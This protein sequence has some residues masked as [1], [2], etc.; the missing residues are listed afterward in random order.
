MSQ[1]KGQKL[2]IHFTGDSSIIDAS[3]I[4][5]ELTFSAFIK[6]LDPPTPVDD[7]VRQYSNGYRRKATT[8]IGSRAQGQIVF[9]KIAGDRLP[10]LDEWIES[11]RGEREF[12]IDATHISGIHRSITAFAD[13]N[14]FPRD[15]VSGRNEYSLSIKYE[16]LN[17][18]GHIKVN[19]VSLQ[20]GVPVAFAFTN[21]STAP[22]RFSHIY[23]PESSVDRSL[24]LRLT[25]SRLRVTCN[26]YRI[27]EHDGAARTYNLALRS[28]YL[29]EGMNAIQIESLDYNSTWT[30][31]DVIVT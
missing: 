12:I 1:Q 6:R 27:M 23:F 19:N 7:V 2:L 16:A 20:F 3:R 31:R 9:D 14:E 26:G 22:A 21:L 10:L 25:G 24:S 18:T 29:M 5:N 28:A 11:V 15:R 4:G 30:V 8:L 13:E 17:D